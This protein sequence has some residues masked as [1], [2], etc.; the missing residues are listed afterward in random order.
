MKADGNVCLAVL[1]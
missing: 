1:V